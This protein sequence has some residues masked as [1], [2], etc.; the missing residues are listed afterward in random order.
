MPT[1]VP[2]RYIGGTTCTFSLLTLINILIFFPYFLF[3][4][5]HFFFCV[6]NAI[7]FNFHFIIGKSLIAFKTNSGHACNFWDDHHHART[8]FLR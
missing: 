2:T 3:L 8:L 4:Y 7:Y 5:K 6:C 1:A